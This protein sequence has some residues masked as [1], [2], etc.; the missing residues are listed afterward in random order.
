M[1]SDTVFTCLATVLLLGLPGAPYAACRLGQLVELPVTMRD[2][3]AVVS[4]QINGEALEFIVDSGNFYSLLSLA[5]AKRLHLHLGPAPGNFKMGGV[6]GTTDLQL[7]NVRDFRLATL[8]I[9]DID[10]L[11]GGSE[12]GNAGNLGQ[13]VLGWR[14]AEYDLANGV[15]RLLHPKDCG[16]QSLAY[17]AKA[18]PVS[19]IDIEPLDE[20]M[21][22]TIGPAY[23]NGTR[24]RVAFDTG[25]PAS[26]L[27]RRTA[28]RAGFK[29]DGPDAHPAGSIYGAGQAWVRTW[30]ARFE[31]FKLGG[32]EIRNANLRVADTTF[33][34]ID[35][36]LGVDF[37]LS[38]RIYVSNDQHRLYFT[39]NG[40]PVF[41]L[42]DLK[43]QP[44]TEP[45][46]ADSS[47]TAAAPV[48]AMS[49]DTDSTSASEF[50]RRG[51][52]L[53]ARH[54]Y[55][56]AIEALNRAC[57][58]APMESS[59]FA[60]R[61]QIYGESGQPDKAVADLDQALLLKPD[62]LEALVARA[63]LRHARD[64]SAGAIADLNTAAEVSAKEAN[65]RLDLGMAY[66]SL[67]RFPEAIAQFDLWIA[68]HPEDARLAVALNGRCRARA[69][70]GQQLDRA[71]SD[72]THAL[73][74]TPNYVDALTSRGMVRLRLGDY[75]KSIG[76]YNEALKLKPDT[77]WALYGRGL[78]KLR[79][80]SNA[81]AQADI[82]A[83]RRLQPNIAE[84]AARYALAP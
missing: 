21:R 42:K 29:F 52:A 79:L 3:H 34:D 23:L 55:A 5:T 18:E 12:V 31:S 57:E 80:G 48:P 22:H 61:G 69:L 6:N 2:D 38:H 84:A 10:F 67:E 65:V 39:Y 35:M 63:S 75:K 19:I 77:A 47:A 25:S 24:I 26:M 72:C 41:N 53:A 30:T 51:M 16:K 1:R 46:A 49:Q 28:E 71:L 45:P 9:P 58:L 27:T 60:E 36:L 59:Y 4:A 64:E 78:A 83:A 82:A 43:A 40:G 37:F 32:E 70:L 20:A 33:G 76:D 74:A 62:N 8:K 15:V 13:N 17:W 44:V 56:H 50:T 68:V 81:D 11:V 73:W 7:T 14:D 66:E 54:D